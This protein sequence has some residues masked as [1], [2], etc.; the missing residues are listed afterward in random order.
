MRSSE[1]H[2]PFYL[3]LLL[4]SVLF[5]ATALGYALV[6]SLEEKAVEAGQVPPHSP[7]R[8]ALRTDGWKWLLYEVGA[9]I[10]FGV[11][12]MGLDR[13][14]TLKKERARSDNINQKQETR[15][16]K[17]DKSDA[18]IILFWFLVSHF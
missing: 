17:P 18:S 11:L 8:D 16:Q 13:L 15:N 10:V 4:A 3:L 1:P 9:M 2:N 5:A 7:F 12:S 6:P 14:R